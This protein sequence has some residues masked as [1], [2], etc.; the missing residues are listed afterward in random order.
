[1]NPTTNLA[2]EYARSD[3]EVKRL[4]QVLQGE[5][6]SIIAPTP[7]LPGY[8]QE[9]TLK[10]GLQVPA[11][12]SLVTSGFKY[13]KVLSR[14]EVS[15]EQWSTF[16]HEVTEH[17]NMTASQWLTTIGSAFG[18]FAVGN[19]MIGFLGLI[20]SVVVGHKMRKHREERNLTAAVHTGALMTC[21]KRWNETYF[22]PRGLIVRVDVPGVVDDMEN[23]DVSTSKKF[24][25]ET[26]PSASIPVNRDPTYIKHLPNE[27]RTRMKAALRGRIV[28]IPLEQSSL[29]DSNPGGPQNMSPVDRVYDDDMS[30]D[31][32]EV[33]EE[34]I[35]MFGR[36]LGPK[37]DMYPN[38]PKP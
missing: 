10:R 21:V 27:S 2:P 36:L 7:T 24:Q 11:R 19:I 38:E 29:S 1:M 35:S 15:K 30:E 4:P 28:I 8:A 31:E 34:D 14:A 20:P 32:T 23:M 25:Y 9:S 5:D 16:T 33:G 22:Q 18:T 12:S 6:E 17:A 3:A 13:P 37:K 26:S